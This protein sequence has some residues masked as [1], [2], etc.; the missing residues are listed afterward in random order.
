MADSV[1][2]CSNNTS[3]TEVTGGYDAEFEPALDPKYICP[4]CLAALRSPLQTKCGHRFCKMCMQKIIGYEKKNAVFI[5]K[6]GLLDLMNPT[7]HEFDGR[8]PVQ[9]L[10]KWHGALM[11]TKV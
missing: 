5:S 1:R 9:G 11:V 8:H 10:C 4:V 7:S 2:S 3:S 6:E